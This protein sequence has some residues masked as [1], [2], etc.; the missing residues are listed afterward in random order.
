V[1]VLKHLGADVTRQNHI[2][3]WGTQFGMLIQYLDEH[4]QVS[5]KGRG[6][7]T[8]SALEGSRR[9]R[10]TAAG[11][12]QSRPH[13]SA[14]RPQR[15]APG[16]RPPLR[17]WEVHDAQGHSQPR[18]MRQNQQARVICRARVTRARMPP[19][20]VLAWRSLILQSCLDPETPQRFRASA[21]RLQAGKP[22]SRRRRR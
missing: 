8:M 9:R 5:W 12:Q 10:G 22:A 18:R 20:A 4:P 3:D 16:A 11:G 14:L 15:S 7:E 17:R 2:G 21:P 13:D 6:A 19:C 1:R